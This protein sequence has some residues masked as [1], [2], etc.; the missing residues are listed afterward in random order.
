MTLPTSWNF[1][2]V[3]LGWGQGVGQ[4]QALCF[5]PVSAKGCKAGIQSILGLKQ[6]AS[7]SSAGLCPELFP[8]RTD[9]V[10]KCWTKGSLQRDATTYNLTMDKIQKFDA[11][12]SVHYFSDISRELVSKLFCLF[13][14]EPVIL[15]SA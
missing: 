7:A 10:S 8:H 2:K 12:V 11:T 9:G 3:G 1:L 6:T 14:W 15:I 4:D 5:G 13:G